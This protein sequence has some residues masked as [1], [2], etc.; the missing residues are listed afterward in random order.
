MLI[1]LILKKRHRPVLIHIKQTISQMND[2]PK[3]LRILS[4][5]FLSKPNLTKNI[6]EERSLHESQLD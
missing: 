5:E 3:M 6:I 1:E 4:D 2:L